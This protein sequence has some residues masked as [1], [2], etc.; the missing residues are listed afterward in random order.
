MRQTVLM[1]SG[2]CRSRITFPDRFG[3]LLYLLDILEGV[4]EGETHRVRQEESAEASNNS[5]PSEQ[6]E[7]NIL[8][9]GLEINEEPAD[10]GSSSTTHPRHYKTKLRTWKKRG[11]LYLLYKPV[12]QM[13]IAV[14]LMVVG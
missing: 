13:P 5:K 8:G 14:F 9:E 6:D 4:W 2:L 12:E 10:D 1:P 7:R 11:F 3:F